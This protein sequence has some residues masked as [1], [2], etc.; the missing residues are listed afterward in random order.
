M[1]ILI[2]WQNNVYQSIFV[3]IMKFLRQ[4]VIYKEKRCTQLTFLKVHLLN[5]MVQVL[6]R[7]LFGCITSWQMQCMPVVRKRSGSQRDQTSTIP[8]KNPTQTVLKNHTTRPHFLKDLLPSNTTTL[9]SKPPTHKTLEVT[10]KP[11]PN[12]GRCHLYLQS[13]PQI[14]IPV[15]LLK[16]IF[17]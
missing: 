17:I 5:S 13:A 14:K 10:W 12:Q 2:N 1:S 15:G 4:T 7:A 16:F 9:G 8:S 3:T 6:E 11:Y